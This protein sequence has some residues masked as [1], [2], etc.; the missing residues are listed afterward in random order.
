M[1]TRKDK[2]IDPRFK[3]SNREA[4]IAIGLA[5]INFL[6]WYGFAYGMGSAP[7]EEYTFVF[8]LP[9]WFFYSCV[10]GFIFITILVF[11]VV[12]FFFSDVPFENEGKEEETQ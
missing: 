9:A 8:G 4:L 2:K 7:V 12:R 5:I 1:D 10:A 11:I 3:V 6:W